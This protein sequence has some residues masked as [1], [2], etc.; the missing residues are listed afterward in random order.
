MS[1]II[2]PNRPGPNPAPPIKPAIIDGAGREFHFGRTRV[3]DTRSARFL[4]RDKLPKKRSVRTSRYWNSPRGGRGLPFDQG[5][6]PQCVEYAGRTLLSA[7]P[8]TNFLAIEKFPRG[9]IYHW[10]QENDYWDGAD[11]DGTSGLALAKWMVVN[12]FSSGYVWEFA[13]ID[14][15]VQWL[16]EMG[17]VLFGTVWPD[18]MVA[19]D[20][21]N[22]LPVDDGPN[23][24]AH[25]NGHE[26]C[27]T[28]VN[29]K[30]GLI[31]I[32]NT[33]GE[34]WARKGKAR[35]RIEDS[36]RLLAAGGDAMMLTELK[37][38]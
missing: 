35:I 32:T 6:T 2:T 7:G 12:G 5:R 37:R 27:A 3:I 22:I 26:Y 19:P 25:A 1:E 24:G 30:T 10:C 16:L 14:V 11:Y 29:T 33:W 17:P 18:S 9:S 21:K 28:G 23:L 13:D 20:A 36:G 8:V 15:V 4:A 31:E 38:K 34:A